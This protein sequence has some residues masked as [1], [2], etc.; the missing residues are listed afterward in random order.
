MAHIA[1]EMMRL[2]MLEL[3]FKRSELM[4]IFCDN[5]SAIYIVQKHVFHERTK[6]IEIDCHL[7]RDAW[8]KD[9]VSLPFTPSSIL[10][11]S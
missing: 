1:C 3:G 9:V 6:H 10:Q 11:S 5:Q 2:N 8:T 4:L 7:A